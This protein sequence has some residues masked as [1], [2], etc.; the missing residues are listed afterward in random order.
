MKKS[1]F[2]ILIVICILLFILIGVFVFHNYNPKEKLGTLQ[3]S[4]RAQSNMV[5]VEQEYQVAFAMRK[6]TL[7][8]LINSSQLLFTVNY[9]LRAGLDFADF[10]IEKEGNNV[11]VYYSAPRVFS[12]DARLDTLYSILAKS[13]GLFSTIDQSDY[14]DDINNRTEEIKEIALSNG[15]N[16]T[17][18][19]N[20][21]LYF[22]SQLVALGV[23]SDNIRFKVGG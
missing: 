11:I 2:P 23:D 5:F 12:V 22:M 9:T 1:W 3:N 7:G 18:I 15:L 19:R 10:S 17:V 14:L 13:K 6:D 20:A 4:L 21:E 16:A 8:G